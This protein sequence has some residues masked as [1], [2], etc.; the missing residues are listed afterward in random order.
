MNI[1][2]TLVFF[3]AHPDD[4]TFGMGATLAQ[5][6]ASGVKVYYVCSTRGEAG[7]VDP[8][9]LQGYQ[10]I[11]DLRTAEMACAAKVLGLAGVIYLGYRDS[12][13]TGSPDN[14]NPDSLFKAPVE[15]VAG[16]MVKIIRELK[17]D[18]I[19]TH[20]AGGGYGHPDHIATHDA[21]VKAFYAAS[22][23]AQFPKAGPPFQPAKL[24]FGSVLQAL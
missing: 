1:Q 22:D 12:G 23:P 8:E 14:Q 24:Y 10:T 20:D 4:E 11:A 2:K 13:M 6:A 19:I 15:Q 3:G 5:Y 7:T 17:P 16:L 21:V 18:V 9:Y